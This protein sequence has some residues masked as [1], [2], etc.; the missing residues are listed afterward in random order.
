MDL[1]PKA[2]S[3]L[4]INL[5]RCVVRRGKPI[6]LGLLDQD[7]ELDGGKYLNRHLII[8]LLYLDI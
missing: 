3:C 5:T 1:L 6:I 8:Y 2:M 7:M 4:I